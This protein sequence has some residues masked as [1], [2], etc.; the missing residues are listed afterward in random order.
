MLEFWKQPKKQLSQILL[1]IT[2]QKALEPIHQAKY[3]LNKEIKR[4]AT[5]YMYTL[6]SKLKLFSI[7]LVV[8]GLIGIVYGFMNVPK[9]IDQ[10]RQILAEQEAHGPSAHSD[11]KSTN[12]V[13][14]ARGQ[15]GYSDTAMETSKDYGPEADGTT[16]HEE[17]VLNQMQARPWSA[18]LVAGFFFTMLTLGVFGFYTIQYAA[19]AGWAPALYRVMEGI[20]VST[21]PGS[22]IVYLIVIYAGTHF[23]PWQH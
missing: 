13:E 12:F 6:P 9:D 8:V 10:V 14:P 5:N 21:L 4:M 11:E 20:T 3:N 16:S 22:L 15:M 1:K 2:I 17:H 18:T 7:I 19:A 23:Y